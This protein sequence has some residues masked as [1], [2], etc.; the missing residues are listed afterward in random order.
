MFNSTADEV[1]AF[2]LVK[3]DCVT[4]LPLMIVTDASIVAPVWTDVKFAISFPY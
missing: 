1:T 2:N 3:S 4:P